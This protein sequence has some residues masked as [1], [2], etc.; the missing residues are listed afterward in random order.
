MVNKKIFVHTTN[1][2]KIFIW[3]LFIG[4]YYDHTLLGPKNSVPVLD[5]LVGNLFCLYSASPRRQN[6]H[7][8]SA[9]PHKNN[10]F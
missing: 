6:D 3:W 5:A 7:L 9:T 2:I 4:R 1:E 8:C 10:L